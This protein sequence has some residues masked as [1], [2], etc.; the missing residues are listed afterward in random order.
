MRG[1]ALALGKPQAAFTIVERLDALRTELLPESGLA[2]SGRR[3]RR[4]EGKLL[5]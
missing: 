1:N 4:R 5:Y 2:S 3:N